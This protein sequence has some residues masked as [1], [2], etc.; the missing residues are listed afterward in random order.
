MARSY[1]RKSRLI[2]RNEQRRRKLRGVG[3]DIKLKRFALVPLGFSQVICRCSK[4]SC[5]AFSDSRLGLRLILLWLSDFSITLLLTFGHT[6]TSFF[7]VNYEF[8][9]MKPLLEGISLQL[10]KRPDYPPLAARDASRRIDRVGGP[11][12]TLE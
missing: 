2:D 5:D 3:C 6:Y 7:N 8:V 10:Q 9:R 1:F 4:S 12:G 11:I